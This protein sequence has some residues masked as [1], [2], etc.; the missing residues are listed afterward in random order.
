VGGDAKNSMKIEISCA[1]K[2]FILEDN[3]ERI[4]WF[5]ERMPKATIVST[6]EDAIAILSQGSF[7]FCFLDHDLCFNDAAFPDRPGSGE[8]VAHYLAQKGFVGSAV[9]H[10]VNEIG[11]MR[12]K[13][14]LHHAQIA[15]FGTFEVSLV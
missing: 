4:R 13:A 8:R 12:M 5:R 2:I 7:D 15:P 10:S 1:C 3:H 14:R 11:A 9:I 6:A